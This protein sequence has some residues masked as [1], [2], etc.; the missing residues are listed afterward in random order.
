[1]KEIF[2]KPN[3]KIGPN[4]VRFK[5]GFTTSDCFFFR[6]T[7]WVLYMVWQQLIWYLNRHLE[8]EINS[9]GSAKITGP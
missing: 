8:L 1:M 7:M 9:R 3:T 2:A 5:T 4:E 6:E